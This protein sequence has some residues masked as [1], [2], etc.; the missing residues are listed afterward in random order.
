MPCDRVNRNNNIHLKPQRLIWLWLLILHRKIP[1]TAERDVGAGRS[2]G[3]LTQSGPSQ[4]Q[5]VLVTFPERKVTR[6]KGGTDISHTTAIGY[7]PQSQPI[8][9][10]HYKERGFSFETISSDQ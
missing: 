9:K 2:E 5:M 10:P 7:A 3:T 4:E 8:K 6:R 1:D